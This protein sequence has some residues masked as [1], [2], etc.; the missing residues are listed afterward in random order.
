[1]TEDLDE[2]YRRA[3]ALDPS[4][5]SEAVRRK[6]LEH[7]AALAAVPRPAATRARWRPAIFGTLAA[8]GLAGLLIMPRIFNLHAPAESA[9]TVAREGPA[10]GRGTTGRRR[11]PMNCAGLWPFRRRGCREVPRH[12]ACRQTGA[13]AQPDVQSLAKA[14][15]RTDASAGAS[16]LGAAAKSGAAAENTTASAQPASPQADPPAALRRAAETGDVPGLRAILSAGVRIDAPDA[17][18]RTA[19]M[20]AAARGQAESVD[21]L[22]AHGADPNAVDANGTTPLNA[23]LAAEQPAIVAALRRAGAR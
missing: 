20:L 7:A 22:L 3:S 6:V 12:R 8:A 11:P 21:L 5:P 10:R 23:A 4:R 2:I 16:R 18:G 1:L 14:T 19:L 9:D 15:P 13:D 17:R